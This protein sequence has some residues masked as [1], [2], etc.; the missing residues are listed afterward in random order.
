[1]PG[2]QRISIRRFR[3]LLQP[4]SA[5]PWLNSDSKT[6]ASGSVSPYPIRTPIRR[7]RSRSCARAASGHVAAPPPITLMKSRRRIASP[8]TS[9]QR[10]VA[11]QTRLVKRRSGVRFGSKADIRAAKSHVCFTPNSDRESEFRPKVVSALPSKADMC[12]AL[13]HVCYGPI[14]DIGRFQNALFGYAARSTRVSISL[15]RAPKSIGLV[16]SASAPL[17]N[18]LRLVSTSP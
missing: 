17:S 15:R 13:G 12:G 14:A 2:A 4:N 18:A 1:L 6:F 5:R 10:I 8:A 16:K 11:V 7:T 3:P 9:G